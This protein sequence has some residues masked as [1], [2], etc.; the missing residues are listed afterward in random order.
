VDYLRQTENTIIVGTNTKG[1]YSTG[2]VVQVKL[3][4]SK[5][6]ISCGFNLHLEPDL[7][8]IEGIGIEPDIWAPPDESLERVI[9][10]IENYGLAD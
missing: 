3:P 8:S 1:A 10:F 2:N 4:Y 5:I 7:P 6:A 9:K